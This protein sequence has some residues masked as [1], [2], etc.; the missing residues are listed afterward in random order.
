[1]TSRW[2]ILHGDCRDVLRTL[3]AASV[4]TVVTS[5]PYFGLRDYGVDGQIGL[6]ESPR[7]FIKEM[8]RVFR[9]VRRVL[10]DDGTLWLNLGDSY[11]GGGRG[12]DTG[13]TLGGGRKSQDESRKAARKRGARVPAGLKRKDLIGM[14]WA[15]AFA[16]RDDGWYLRRDIV[17]QKMNVTPE[18]VFDRPTSEHEYVFLLTKRPDYFYDYDAITEPVSGTSHPRGHG[19]HP[20]SATPSSASGRVKA[21][22]SFSTAVRGLVAKRNARSVWSIPSAPFSESHFAT[23]PPELPRRCILAGTSEVG[24]C[25]SCGAPYARVLGEPEPTG[26]KASGNQ[27]R[28]LAMAGVDDRLDSHLGYSIPWEPT[29]KPTIAWTR[30]CNCAYA[31]PV[32]NVVLDPF[33]GAGT[34]GVVA[35]RL[36]REYVGIELNPEYIAMSERRIECDAPLF[37]IA[38]RR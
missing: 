3:P 11:A 17:W 25:P 33:S 4:Q 18:C 24:A 22:S 26:G 20:K 19:R 1:V 7:Q 12:P 38:G 28:K 32:P 37:N 13:S 15:V 34:T 35:T 36:G 2:R 8:V 9:E 30:A 5:P 23:F 31:P 14:P 16:L 6:E 21:N 29:I 27:Q 10:R